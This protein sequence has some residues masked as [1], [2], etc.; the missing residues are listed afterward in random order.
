MAAAA[1]A[2]MGLPR[3]KAPW[4]A[5]RI[6]IYMHST[7]APPGGQ[8]LRKE[9]V[10]V[11]NIY[12]LVGSISTGPTGR[13]VDS[14]RDRVDTTSR[15]SVGDP[16]LFFFFHPA[17]VKVEHNG[18]QACPCQPTCLCYAVVVTGSLRKGGRGEPRRPKNQSGSKQR[19][20]VMSHTLRF[21]SSRGPRN[22][23]CRDLRT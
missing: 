23:Q 12:I 7:F 9:S 18:H 17:P 1:A 19:E 22:W 20:R 10:W 16:T 6:I 11:K 14:F 4:N 21:P 15:T 5:V 8:R 2:C 13:N 3:G